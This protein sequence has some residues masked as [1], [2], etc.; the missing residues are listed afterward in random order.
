MIGEVLNVFRPARCELTGLVVDPRV[1]RDWTTHPK[2]PPQGCDILIQN[3]RRYG[4]SES[5]VCY[6]DL[7]PAR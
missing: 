4:W 5:N 3:L 1:Q 7:G 6:Q 2:C